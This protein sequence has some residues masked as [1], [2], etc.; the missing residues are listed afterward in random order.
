[1]G[2]GERIRGFTGLHGVAFFEI[3]EIV[4]DV[5]DMKECDVNAGDCTGNTALTWAA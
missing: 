1:M 2:T 4:T 5:L 3:G